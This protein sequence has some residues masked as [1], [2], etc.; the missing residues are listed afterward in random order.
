MARQ[1]SEFVDL[2]WYRY[3]SSDDSVSREERIEMLELIR[4]K[5]PHSA[6]V[7]PYLVN[8]YGSSDVGAGYE[9]IGHWMQRDEMR[10]NTSTSGRCR[11]C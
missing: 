9:A 8:E 1:S 2:L 10:R 11:R 7:F 5:Y 3:I 4:D 6:T